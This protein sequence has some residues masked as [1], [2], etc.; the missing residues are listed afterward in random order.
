MLPREKI[1]EYP[2]IVYC[3]KNVKLLPGVALLVYA[4]GYIIVNS[5]LLQYGIQPQ[6]LDT[7]MI[8]A[9]VL[10]ITIVAF[11]A[12]ALFHP[13]FIKAVKK[14]TNNYKV[15]GSILFISMFYAFL[16]S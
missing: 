14:E 15:I 16:I 6:F 2:L 7:K 5:Y 9:G 10:L 1:E 12:L 11:P 8:I 3:I 13:R 4:A